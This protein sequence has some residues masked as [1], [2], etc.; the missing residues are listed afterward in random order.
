MKKFLIS[1]SFCIFCLT[2]LVFSQVQ[3]HDYQKFDYIKVDQSEFQQFTDICRNVLK[4]A[5][6]KLAES[7]RI[8]SWRLY[9]VGYPGG[10]RS[11]YNFV[12]VLTVNSPGILEELFSSQYLPSF[13]PEKHTADGNRLLRES[14]SLIASEIWK[15]ENIIESDS[16]H[17]TPGRFLVMDYMD[18]APGRGLDYLMLEDE[19][20]KPIH[21]E[22]INNETMRS[23]QAY[24]LVAPGGTG[25][26]YNFSTGNFFDSLE[27]VEFGF[28]EEVINQAIDDANIPELF[29]T[30]FSTR[31]L[32]KSELWELM[33]YARP[34]E[35]EARK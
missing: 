14:V 32:V 12:S 21:S 27:H 16:L 35:T 33:E 11:N 24:S 13:I 20:A 3:R 30:I 9:K 22:R 17:S 4:P 23:W 5:Y 19:I 15:V 34:P 31:T 6:S 29:N 28:T 10:E 25:Y 18:V 8:K 26:G 7:E 2:T 1:S